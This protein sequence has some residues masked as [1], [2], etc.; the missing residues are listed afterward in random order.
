MTPSTHNATN[1]D[2]EAPLRILSKRALEQARREVAGIE[3]MSAA[4]RPGRKADG[5]RRTRLKE[6]LIEIERYELLEQG[7]VAAALGATTFS[8][9]ELPGVLSAVRV[10]AKLSVAELA[11]RLGVAASVIAKSEAKDYQ[12]VSVARAAEILS[13]CG[14]F[15]QCRLEL[16]Q[17]DSGVADAA[18]TLLNSALRCAE[19][20]KPELALEHVERGVRMC[21]APE[22][23]AKRLEL[24][25]LSVRLLH[26]RGESVDALKVARQVLALAEELADI[27]AIAQAHNAC[28]ALAK[29][30]GLVKEASR[31]LQCA[32]ESCRKIGDELTLAMALSNLRHSHG[33]RA[34]GAC[35]GH[36]SRGLDSSA[37]T[38]R[39]C[40]RSPNPF[41]SGHCG[42][43]HCPAPQSPNL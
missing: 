8:L 1:S 27:K 29:L 6:L 31:Y 3:R 16:H 21:A 42:A 32:I 23:G 43:C 34:N 36:V 12:G 9:A 28:G 2:R 7:E 13:S 14:A 33:I 18:H 35:R 38:R 39:C 19:S 15:L 22:C 4:T 26:Q 25:R 17:A 40:G 37:T 11:R 30:Q 5:R 24:L 20:G 41:Q 10:A